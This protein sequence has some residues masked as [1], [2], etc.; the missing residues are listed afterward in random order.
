[1]PSTLLQFRAKGV[2]AQLLE[3]VKEPIRFTK[4]ANHSKKQLL[5][6]IHQTLNI[7]LKAATWLA[8]IITAILRQTS[9]SAILKEHYKLHYFWAK[10]HIACLLMAK[11]Q[12]IPQQS[13][14]PVSHTRR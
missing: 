13:Q 4:K 5:G 9:K 11:K 7:L 10:K 8:Y 14:Q 2:V 1:M 6:R 12:Q 3:E